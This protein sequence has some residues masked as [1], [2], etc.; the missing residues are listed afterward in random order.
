MR[1]Q[2]RVSQNHAHIWTCTHGPS[3]ARGGGGG[4]TLHVHHGAGAGA[5]GT[6]HAMTTALHSRPFQCGCGAVHDSLNK[7]V[8]AR[9]RVGVQCRALERWQEL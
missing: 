3:R 5:G 8:A 7:D 9:A 1:P 2:Q 6:R 4:H